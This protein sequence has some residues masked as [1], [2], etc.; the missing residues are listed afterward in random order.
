MPADPRA[1]RAMNEEVEGSPPISEPLEVPGPTTAEPSSSISHFGI[2]TFAT[3]VGILSLS[4][5]SNLVRAVITAK[6]LAVALGPTLTG[7]LAQILNFST[8]LFQLIPLG[9]TTGVA[10]L[11]ADSPADRA[12]VSAVAG[13]SSLL[14]LASA[15]ICAVLLAPFAN[16][17]SQV[18]T[19]ST[20]YVVPVLL[21]LLSLPLYNVAGV[22]SYVLQGLSDIRGLTIANVA[23]ALTALVVLIPATIAF[24]LVGATAAVAAASI[25]QFGFFA[26]MV[27]RAFR[28][29][30]WSLREVH[31][32]RPTARSLLQY[33][34]VLL[35]AGIG[36]W[37]SLLLVRT[38]GIHMLGQLQNGIYQVVNGVSA[39]YMAVFITW[40]AAYVFPRIVAEK[41][42][43]RTQAMLN[44]T[45][46]A[47]L[48][49]MGSGMVALIALRE[50]VVRLLY[51]P[52]FLAAAP[53]L[54]I[55]VL[56]DYARV[57]GWSFGITLFAHGRTRAYLLA[58]LVQ[59]GLWILLAPLAM[60][61]FGTAA[62]AMG[63]SLSSL[64]WPVLM[65]PMV[66]RWFGVRI[67]GEGA[68]LAVVGLVAMVG[69]VLLP[70]LPG[71]ALA[72]ALPLTVYAV[73]RHQR[74][75]PV[76]P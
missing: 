35:V 13:T 66:R 43:V 65:Y 63:Y 36:S 53:I 42:P 60:R 28:A 75:L 40:M 37:G 5:I 33:G 64:A 52:A 18:L 50:L 58:M 74:R 19:G 27:W 68:L 8:F 32:A 3:S 51:S 23:T 16:Q 1:T 56:G 70:A 24:K 29:R 10:K 30:S 54:P 69:A 31:F 21:V 6:L 26:F 7:D 11:V 55:Q 44:A 73:R 61:Q 46:R 20:A 12:K 34:G 71:L 15:T 47:N 72:A 48:L 45:L 38:I 62:I 76:G 59:D 67:N 9:L 25:L 2:R 14:S 17:L 57:I 22:L 4:S 39:Q 41:D 49:I